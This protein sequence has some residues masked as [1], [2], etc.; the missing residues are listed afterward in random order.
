ML[1]RVEG[2]PLENTE[3]VSI[4]DFVRTIAVARILM[5]MSYVRLSAGRTAMSDEGQALCFF[6]GANSMFYGEQL[7]TTSNPD[8]ENDKALFNTLGITPAA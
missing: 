3:A 5:P 1:V 2:T 4:I 8:L 7:L 6:A